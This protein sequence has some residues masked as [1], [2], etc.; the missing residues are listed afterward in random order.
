MNGSFYSSSIRDLVDQGSETVLGYLAKQNPF[1]LDALQRNAWLSQIDLV[2]NQLGALEGWVAFEFA[3]PRM[4]KR[5]DVVLVTAES[6]C[7][8]FKVAPNSMLR[9]G[10]GGR[11]RA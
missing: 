8:E 1:A 3:I 4:G 2:R 5:A 9:Y 10:S 6:F 11:L 7:P